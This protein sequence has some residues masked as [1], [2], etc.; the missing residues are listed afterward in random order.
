MSLIVEGV[1][2]VPD[3]F[4]GVK[5][6]GEQ[7]AQG[8]SGITS[9]CVVYAF[10]S[11]NVNRYEMMSG[12]FAVFIYIYIYMC[13]CVFPLWVFWLLAWAVRLVFN[14]SW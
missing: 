13:V 3:C 10:N 14:V 11:C 2:G 4:W 12:S 1:F 5:V 6:C 9:D 8:I 7:S